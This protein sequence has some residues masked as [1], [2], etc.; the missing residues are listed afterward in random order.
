MKEKVKTIEA[1]FG[2]W[3]VIDSAFELIY[4]RQTVN[5]KYQQLFDVYHI[6]TLSDYGSKIHDWQQ[7]SFSKIAK[8]IVV[9]LGHNRGERISTLNRELAEYSNLIDKVQ[10]IAVYWD[11]RFAIPHRVPTTQFIGFQ[12]IQRQICGSNILEEYVAEILKA[13]NLKR[14]NFYHDYLMLRTAITNLVSLAHA[15]LT[16]V[17]RTLSTSLQK[18]ATSRAHSRS[19]S[20]LPSKSTSRSSSHSTSKSVWS[21]TAQSSP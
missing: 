15:R 5:L 20:S 7:S 3:S 21:S 17:Q 9:K 19:D 2:L 6:L 8:L 12:V 1:A 4:A 14:Q 11:S 16:L 13:I 10:K 18:R